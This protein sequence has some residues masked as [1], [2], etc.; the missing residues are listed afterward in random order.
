VS[1]RVEVVT[2]WDGIAITF[3]L[4]IL[5]TGPAPALGT[6]YVLCAV[7]F[8]FYDRATADRVAPRN[9]VPKRK[10]SG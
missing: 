7:G 6:L 3:G 10:G 4:F 1:A 9:S 5:A 8:G 2:R